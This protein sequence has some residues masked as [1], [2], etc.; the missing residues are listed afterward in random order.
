MTFTTN[1][2]KKKSITQIVHQTSLKARNIL[3]VYGVL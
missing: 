1:D 3:L 2:R